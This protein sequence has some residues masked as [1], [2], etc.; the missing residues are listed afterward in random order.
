MKIEKKLGQDFNSLTQRILYSYVAT[1]P[2]FK[3][4]DNG[5]SY[6]S[7]MQMHDFIADTL[8]L[9]YEHQEILGVPDVPDAYYENWALNNSNPSL[10]KSM[11]KIEYKFA[12]FIQMLIKIGQLGEI[13]DN[14]LIIQKEKWS[15]TKPIKSKLELLGINCDQT[16]EQ[17]VLSIERYPFIFPAWKAYSVSDDLNAPKISRVIAFIHGRY[18]DKKYRAVDFFDELVEN[19]TLLEQLENYLETNQFKYY[20][21]D[22]NSN[23]RYAYVKWMKEYPKNDFASMR[24][25]FD[26]RKKNQMIFEFRLPQ[27][28]IM[29]NSYN[30]MNTELQQFVFH[31]LKTCNNCGYCTQTD[32]S[33]KRSC[34]AL[35]LICDD[36][37]LC[38]C[39]LYP[40]LT[41]N[42]INANEINNMLSLFEFSESML[43][44]C[45]K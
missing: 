33:G 17:S 10:I 7:Q 29:L 16:K 43:I 18:G 13:E 24:V 32:K 44:N 28:R 14:K 38:K 27:F 20:N 15:L 4:M 2:D 34:L 9:L 8:L 23:T 40:N 22:P 41:F 11:E 12:D 6:E 37:T 3:P 35:N 42:Y 26:W 30:D 21:F 36:K 25:Y 1:F 39:P 5:V 19:A 45:T 31:R